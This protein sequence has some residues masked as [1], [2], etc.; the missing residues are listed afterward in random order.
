MNSFCNHLFLRMCEEISLELDD[1][2]ST[3]KDSQLSSRQLSL[4]CMFYFS[5]TELDEFN[6]VHAHS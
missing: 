2:L 1:F 6:Q 4:L 5:L 3:S